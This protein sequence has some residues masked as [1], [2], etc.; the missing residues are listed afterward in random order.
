MPETDTDSERDVTR[1]EP[2]TT[3][4]SDAAESDGATENESLPALTDVRPHAA[5]G[6]AVVVAF[7][8]GARLRYRERGDRVVEVWESPD[9]DRRTRERE[10]DGGREAAAL[11]A[12]GAYLS[13]E[14][15]R[16]AAFVWGGENVATLFGDRA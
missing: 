5:G 15:R 10:V 2:S 3:A 8:N 6:E 11:R 14:D 13:F 7:E 16:R 12:V 4:A 9:G 1:T